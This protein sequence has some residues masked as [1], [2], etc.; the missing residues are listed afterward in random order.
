VISKAEQKTVFL[1]HAIE[2]P[3]VIG[4]IAGQIADFFHPVPAPRTRVKIRHDPKG[5][6]NCLLECLPKCNPTNQFWFVRRVG[7]EQEIQLR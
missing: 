4:N 1:W 7:I 3:G 5:A 6:S 2:A